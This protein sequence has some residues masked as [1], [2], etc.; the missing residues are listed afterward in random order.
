M[1]GKHF[2]PADQLSGRVLL[3]PGLVSRKPNL[4]QQAGSRSFAQRRE[5]KGQNLQL[6]QLAYF[7]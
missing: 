4:M 5:A 2:P 1:G 7:R 6:F 3:A